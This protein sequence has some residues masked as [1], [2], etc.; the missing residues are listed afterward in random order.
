MPYVIAVVL[1]IAAFGLFFVRQPAIVKLTKEMSDQE[2]ALNALNDKLKEYASAPE[3]LERLLNEG[4]ALVER[5]E[6]LRRISE[7]H[8]YWAGTL[9][10]INRLA[11]ANLWFQ[12][13][14]FA[15]SSPRVSAEGFC[16][17][18]LAK[19]DVLEFVSGL[20]ENSRLKEIFNK[21]RLVSCDPVEDRKNLE[22][23]NIEMQAAGAKS[24]AAS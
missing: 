24:G 6:N 5:G 11:P 20:Q 14:L 7:S 4:M 22:K 21:I 15:T 16:S 17:G 10:E 12:K 18:E 13:L 2:T 1:Y 8:L 23:F 3:K 19:R 9:H